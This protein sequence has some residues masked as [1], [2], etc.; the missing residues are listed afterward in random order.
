MGIDYSGL[1]LPKHPPK[2][3][4]KFRVWVAQMTCMV[5]DEACRGLQVHFAHVATGTR[6]VGMKGDDEGVPLCFHHHINELTGRGP[7]WFE[8]RYGID[9][10]AEAR[11][12]REEWEK[13]A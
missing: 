1:A 8:A 10:H 7:T 12:L 9:L 13:A 11:R 4:R 5:N 2:R 6:G 3:D